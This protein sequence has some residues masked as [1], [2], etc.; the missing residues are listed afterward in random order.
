MATCAK[1]DSQIVK[2]AKSCNECGNNPGKSAFWSG[3]VMSIIGV[4]TIPFLIGIV[5]LPLGLAMIW[6][7]KRK[8]TAAEHG[9]G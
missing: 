4:I 6:A 5:L 1:C 7:G 3:V 8:F 9:W 2:E